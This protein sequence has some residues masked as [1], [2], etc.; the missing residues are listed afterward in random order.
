MDPPLVESS[1]AYRPDDNL[2]LSVLGIGAFIFADLVHEVIG[3]GGACL[4][5]G[6]TITL[7]TSVYFRCNLNS[8]IIDAAGPLANLLFGGLFWAIPRFWKN[9]SIHTRVF[10]ASTMSFNF[11]WGSGYLIYSGITNIGDWAYVVEGLQ[12]VWFWRFLLVLLGV[13]LYYLSMRALAN[14]L[15]TLVAVSEGEKSRRIRVIFMI[16]YVAAGLA[17]CLAA[18]F[19][20]QGSLL[21]IKDGALETFCASIGFLIVARRLAHRKTRDQLKY[22]PVTR[23]L[24]WV[25]FVAL[26]LVAFI[27]TMGR[28]MRF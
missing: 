5:S 28:G 8:K 19:D 1:N 12:P 13:T 3:H 22:T 10:V 15:W 25:V 27:V 24:S 20:R 16:P 17:E 11:F 21:A 26:L 14:G 4:A 2:T 18:S 7:L 6:G 9:I 23:K